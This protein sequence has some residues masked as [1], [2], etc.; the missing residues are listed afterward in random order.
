M[1]IPA[2]IGVASGA[3]FGVLFGSVYDLRKKIKVF[4]NAVSSRISITV[5]PEW[6]EIVK[7]C[8][9]N[10]KTDDEVVDFVKELR[11]EFHFDQESSFYLKDFGFVA[12]YDGV[13]GLHTCWS[14]DLKGFL[15]EMEIQGSVFEG[16]SS[17]LYEKFPGNKILVNIRIAP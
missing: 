11:R 3:A 8:F 4:E 15:S 2:W 7:W 5:L 9:P 1:Y 13:S 17:D 6:F 16:D 14:T 10:L 12:F